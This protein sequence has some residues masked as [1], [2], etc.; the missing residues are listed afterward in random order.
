MGPT[1]HGMEA[2]ASGLWDEYLDQED[3]LHMEGLPWY[4]PTCQCQWRSNTDLCVP[5]MEPRSYTYC[6]NN[7]PPKY[8]AILYMS[9]RSKVE[10][11]EFRAWCSPSSPHG[12]VRGCSEVKGGGAHVS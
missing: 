4:L 12:V 2:H 3:R 7:T 10:K 5:T 1:G 11:I 9:E 6:P 8:E